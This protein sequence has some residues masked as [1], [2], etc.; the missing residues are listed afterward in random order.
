MKNRMKSIITL[1]DFSSFV[2]QLR[3]LILISR[4]ERNLSLKQ[5][6]EIKINNYNL[7]KFFNMEFIIKLNLSLIQLYI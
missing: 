3:L 6:C 4:I 2:P 5:I 1:L 7:K